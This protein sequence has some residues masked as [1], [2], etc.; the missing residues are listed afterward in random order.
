MLSKN[1]IFVSLPLDS[2]F[3]CELFYLIIEFDPIHY[4]NYEPS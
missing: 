1:K 2:I 4:K 3:L